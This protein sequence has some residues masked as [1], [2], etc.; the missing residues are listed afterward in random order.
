MNKILNIGYGNVKKVKIGGN[1][2]LVFIGGPCAIEN[3]SIHLNREIIK[4]ICEKL[5]I[6]W[7][8]KA[9][10]TKIVDL[11]LKAFMALV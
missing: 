6:K 8:F 5:N 11:L 9:V 7:I 2:P 3:E 1:N 10:M 4:K